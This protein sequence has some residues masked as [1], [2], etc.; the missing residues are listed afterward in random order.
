MSL[1]LFIKQLKVVQIVS[2]GH[3]KIGLLSPGRGAIMLEGFEAATD[4]DIP[5]T[6]GVPLD[7]I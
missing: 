6:A 3:F 5:A 2:D 7:A 1:V 4:G